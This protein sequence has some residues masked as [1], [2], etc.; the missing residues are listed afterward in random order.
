MEADGSTQVF[1]WGFPSLLK[2]GSG[3]MALAVV[4][5]ALFQSFVNSQL[6]ITGNECVLDS[7]S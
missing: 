1:S 4:K 7:S 3:H 5:K 6:Q 2:L